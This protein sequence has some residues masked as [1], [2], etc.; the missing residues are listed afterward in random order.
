MYNR[1][2]NG[3]CMATIRVELQEQ[4]L[5]LKSYRYS[6][7]YDSLCSAHKYRNTLFIPE[8]VFRIHFRLN[9]HEPL[10]ILIEVLA[11][12]NLSFFKAVLTEVVHSNIKVSIIQ[13][14][15]SGIARHKRCHVTVK[16]LSLIR[17]ILSRTG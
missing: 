17:E 2:N 8:K 5:K 9:V 10:Q 14:S 6:S 4:K 13:K 7:L 16:P 12:I 1:I 11:P 3:Q 15:P